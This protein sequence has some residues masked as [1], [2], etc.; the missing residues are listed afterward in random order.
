VLLVVMPLVL[1][2]GYAEGDTL[3]NHLFFGRSGRFVWFAVLAN[4]VA[5]LA[6]ISAWF[7]I[8]AWKD[9]YWAGRKL[10]TVLRVHYTMLSLAALLLIPVFNYSNLLG[11]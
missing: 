10:G 11:F 1:L 4:L 8:R 9:H 5:I 6:V 3:V 2:V 7:T